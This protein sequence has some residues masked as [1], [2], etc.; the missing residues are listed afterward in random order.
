MTAHCWRSS[1]PDMAVLRAPVPLEQAERGIDECRI[2]HLPAGA[3]SGVRA[4]VRSLR[5]PAA[6]GDRMP[7]EALEETLAWW[8]DWAGRFQQQTPWRDAVMRSLLTL[9]G[10]IYHPT[11]GMVAAATSSLPEMPGGGA[12]LGLP[13]FLA[14]RRHLHAERAAERRLQGRGRRAGATG[15]C[16]RSPPRQR[17]CASCIASMAAGGWTRRR[18][19]GCRATKAPAPVRVGNSAAAQRQIDVVG[20]LLD[21][22]DLMARGGVDGDAGKPGGG[23]RT[24]GT[25]GRHLAGQG[26]RAVGI[27]RPAASL[28][29]LHRDGLGRRGPLPAQQRAARNAGRR[30]AGPPARAARRASMP[31]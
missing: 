1:V 21:A 8:R 31:R 11:G 14:A 13:L 18:S 5:M 3:G 6:A 27:A 20:E 22:L 30:H 7:D 2:R 4:D 17:K 19:T 10:L 28:H 9:K 23:T 16:A 15:C 29:L 25:P 12:E 24:G 26:P